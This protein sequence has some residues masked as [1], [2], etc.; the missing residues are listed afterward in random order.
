ME[1]CLRLIKED[2]PA[3][4]ADIEEYV[5]S[6]LESACED[7]DAVDDVYNG[8][9]ELL[10]GVDPAK[11]EE[12]VREL[13]A[14]LCFVL[15]P[16][17]EERA[18]PEPPAVQRVSAI[19]GYGDSGQRPGVVTTFQRTELEPSDKTRKDSQVKVESEYSLQ[20][21]GESKKGGAS[22]AGKKKKGGKAD[23]KKKN[24]YGSSEVNS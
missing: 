19:D 2:F 10:H 4:D 17:W 7:L 11:T 15:K 20:M 1:D 24:K 3:I 13:C 12:E 5:S 8:I 22:K 6:V 23:A 21:V 14:K 18:P 9:G 16:N